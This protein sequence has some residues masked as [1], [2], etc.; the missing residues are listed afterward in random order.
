MLCY[1]MT[2]NNADGMQR[3]KKKGDFYIYA[4]KQKRESD[5]YL[6]DVFL[7]GLCDERL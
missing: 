6:Y 3:A 5:F 1:F 2:K 7:Y 4:N